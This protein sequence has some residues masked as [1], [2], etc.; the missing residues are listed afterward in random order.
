[1]IREGLYHI[2]K[3]GKKITHAF[4]VVR[5]KPK[6]SNA[7]IACVISGRIIARMAVNRN[8]TIKVQ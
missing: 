3:N 4:W 7:E 1:M 5:A 6:L 2:G 8:K